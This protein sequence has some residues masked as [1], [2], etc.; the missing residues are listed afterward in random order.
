M[1]QIRIFRDSVICCAIA[2][3]RV[4]STAMAIGLLGLLFLGINGCGGGYYTAGY[5]RGYYAPNYGR[6]YGSYGYDGSP[7]LGYNGFYN[8]PD[9]VMRG[10]PHPRY[11]GYH[12]VAQDRDGSPSFTGKR[13]QVPRQK[14]QSAKEK[15][16]S[17]LR[18]S[19]KE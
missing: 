19:V 10:V 17:W 14:G 12:G 13:A 15:S 11:Y 7:F 2:R 1:K 18:R 3:I 8:G 6:Y 4:D 5:S 9:F 16:V